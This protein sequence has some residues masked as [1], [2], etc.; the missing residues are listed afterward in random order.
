MFFIDTRNEEKSSELRKWCSDGLPALG[1]N[2]ASVEA[3]KLPKLQ[4]AHS[5]SSTN[6][7]ALSE[8][9]TEHWTDDHRMLKTKSFRK[10]KSAK[11]P[12]VSTCTNMAKIILRKIAKCLKQK[13]GFFWSF[14]TK[15]TPYNASIF[16]FL[17]SSSFLFP[18]NRYRNTMVNKTMKVLYFRTV[19]IFITAKWM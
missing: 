5:R 15:K 18:T 4:V 8:Y 12:L 7:S 6:H 1:S 13:S 10:D 2:L 11:F 17:W 16:T 3:D 9:G 14:E 19:R